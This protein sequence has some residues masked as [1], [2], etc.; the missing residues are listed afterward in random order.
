MP[1]PPEKKE[2]TPMA[3]K[4]LQADYKHIIHEPVPY[5]IAHPLEENILEW[6]YLLFG[7]E[8]TPYEGGYYHGKL[9]FPPEFPLAPPSIYMITPNG[10]FKPDTRLCLSISDFH[11]DRWNPAYTVSSILVALTSFMNEEQIHYGGIKATDEERRKLAEESKAYNLK[12]AL[13]C[14]VFEM[15]LP[16]LESGEEDESDM[17]D[18][19]DEVNEE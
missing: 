4:R 12:N 13:F 18:D 8:D 15:I 3:V 2:P 14:K 5:A 16:M 17:D 9:I 7:S 11:P 6:H 10:R 19:V 1:K